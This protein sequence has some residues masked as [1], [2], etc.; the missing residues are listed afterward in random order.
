ME[1]QKFQAL[2]GDFRV[3]LCRLRRRRDPF[4]RLDV[5]LF[6]RFVFF[7]CCQIRPRRFEPRRRFFHFG[8]A[9]KFFFF[10]LK[11]HLSR[12][13]RRPCRRRF[14]QPCFDGGE[15][16]SERF[17]LRAALHAGGFCFFQIF[18][19]V[20]H[21]SRRANFGKLRRFRFHLGEPRCE[22]HRRF[23]GCREPGVGIC[24]RFRRVIGL[25]HRD[26]CCFRRFLRRFRFFLRISRFL[27]FRR[28]ILRRFRAGIFQFHPDLCF[29]FFVS[30]RAR[31]RPASQ[32]F[33]KLSVY[34]RM[35][36]LLH[37]GLAVAAVRQ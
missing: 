11:R 24:K 7:S 16:F 36:Q 4:G 35:K 25:A 10:F 1:K 15:L 21:A 13:Q 18:F 9:Q 14:R 34:F 33:H 2:G 37:D 12:S 8:E 19:G 20:L 31:A 32:V 29:D 28:Q 6:G 3:F 22:F 26:L 30:S 5:F 17:R 27:R 23:F